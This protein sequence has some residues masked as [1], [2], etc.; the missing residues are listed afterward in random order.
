MGIKG[1]NFGVFIL[2]IGW[3]IPAWITIGL[4][5]SLA[6]YI[7]SNLTITVELDKSDD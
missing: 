7:I 1:L 3:F 6:I 2:I 4:T 5:V